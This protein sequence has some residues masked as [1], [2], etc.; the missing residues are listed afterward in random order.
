MPI[1]NA[2]VLSE[3]WFE[4]V[5][6]GSP[7]PIE[8]AGMRVVACVVV[9]PSIGLRTLARP[10]SLK[11]ARCTSRGGP[12]ATGSSRSAPSRRR[13]LAVLMSRCKMRSPCRCVRREAA[14]RVAQRRQPALPVEAGVALEAEPAQ[15]LESAVREQQAVVERAAAHQRRDHAR[16]PRVVAVAEE[17]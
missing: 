8:K 16:R 10:T 1:P 7:K 2:S 4:L 3:C 17:K 12:C 14:G 13:M 15:A 6:A 9:P 11:M 5:S